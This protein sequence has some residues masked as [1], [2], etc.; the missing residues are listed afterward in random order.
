MI[1]VL[2]SL[3]ML[4]RLKMMVVVWKEESTRGMEEEEICIAQANNSGWL[5]QGM[6]KRR[7]KPYLIQ[8]SPFSSAQ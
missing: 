5:S 1:M 2:K 7:H 8:N 3:G 6:H 4:M